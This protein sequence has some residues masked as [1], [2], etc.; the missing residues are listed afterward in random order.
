MLFQ[1]LKPLYTNLFY[2]VYETQINLMDLSFNF[3]FFNFF[4]LTVTMILN[5]QHSLKL[6][7]ILKTAT[8]LKNLTHIY[9]IF[10]SLFIF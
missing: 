2:K 8:L 5:F 9:F 1:Y 4:R 3:F 10:K 6:T 7:H